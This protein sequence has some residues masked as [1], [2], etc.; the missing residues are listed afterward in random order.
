MFAITYRAL[1]KRSIQKEHNQR[2]VALYM[3]RG[4]MLACQEQIKLLKDTRVIDT[5][6]KKIDFDKTA[7]DD[8]T[9]HK[10]LT[11]PFGDHES[12]ISFASQGVISEEE[13]SD[14]NGVRT[15]FRLLVTC[16]IT[17]HDLDVLKTKAEAEFNAAI[18]KAEATIK[19]GN[20]V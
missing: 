13:F 20:P 3:L 8:D 10:L 7:D 14:Y 2:K 5:I 6:L 1:D 11:T 19:K 12:I 17:Y 4:T 16:L 18:R 9:Y 15:Y